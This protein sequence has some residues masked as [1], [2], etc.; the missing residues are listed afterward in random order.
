MLFDLGHRYRAGHVIGIN[1]PSVPYDRPIQIGAILISS[2]GVLNCVVDADD[3]GGVGFLE[4][5]V[6]GIPSFVVRPAKPAWTALLAPVGV[7]RHLG[8]RAELDFPIFIHFAD[9]HVVDGKVVFDLP[10]ID[11]KQLRGYLADDD[12]VCR[13]TR[14]ICT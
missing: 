3:R 13:Y 8:K 9:L 10:T 2:H 1:V 7:E 4:E 11:S 6:Q 12:I 14:I 5:H